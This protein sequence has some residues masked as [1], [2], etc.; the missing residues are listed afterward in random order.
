MSTWTD[1]RT[2]DAKRL[3]AEGASASEVASILNRTYPSRPPVSRNSVIGKLHRLGL[4]RS[5]G[6]T[7]ASARARAVSMRAKPKAPPIK[8]PKVYNPIGPKVL[9]DKTPPRK[10]NAET[11]KTYAGIVAA[12]NPKPWIER[13]AE[14]CA[15]IVEFNGADSKACCA[16]I[17][18]RGEHNRWC[19]D[20]ATVGLDGVAKSRKYEPSS[21]FVKWLARA[22]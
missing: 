11:L 12:S 7:V 21:A 5:P 9:G 4:S 6:A 22:A 19:A 3:W 14:E 8:G 17:C 15:W 20:H 10:P 18:S 13:G 2:A 1:E 16:P